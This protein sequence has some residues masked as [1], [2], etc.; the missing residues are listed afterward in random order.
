[1]SISS[2]TTSAPATQVASAASS[3]FDFG[4]RRAE[5]VDRL[6]FAESVPDAALICDPREI[7]YLTGVSEGVS[8]LA[9]W[10]GGCFAMTRHMLVREVSHVIGEC[11]LFLPSKR[12]TDPANLEGFVTSE[13]SRRHFKKVAVDLGRMSAATYFE[14]KKSASIANL[15][16]VVFPRLVDVLRQRKD[17]AETSLISR[18]VAISEGAFAGLIEEGAGG[19]IGRSE[20]QIARELESR[21]L[22]L[23]ADRQGFPDSGIIVASGPN[24]ASAHHCPGGRVVSAGEPLLIDWGAELNGYRSDMTRTLF[25]GTLPEFAR[26]AYP[27]VEAALAAAQ[28]VL[29]VGAKMGDVDHAAREIVTE[30][31]YQEFHYGVGHGVG[32]AIHEGPWLRAHSEEVLEAGM[33]TTVEPGIYLPS[34]GGIRIESMYALSNRGV[35]RL[36]RLPVSLNEMVLS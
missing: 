19:L 3:V 33:I 8:W 36:D 35:D 10:E 31:G 2:S 34:I 5:L 30:A 25:M 15:D 12:S 32:L 17:A 26:K 23:G 29:A 4:K 11:E 21:M 24:S 9:V 28:D 1:M 27:V 18:C 20:F 22:D 16:L 6:K 7:C 13:L 14:L